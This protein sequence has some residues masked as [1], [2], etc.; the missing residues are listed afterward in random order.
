MKTSLNT[1]DGLKRSLTVEL[2]IDSFNEKKDKIITNLSKNAKIDGFRK[3]KIPVAILRQRFG[4]NASSDATNEM[5]SESLENA[6][7]DVDIM[8]A[9][10]PALTKVD[11]DDKKTFSYTIEFEVFPEINVAPLADLSIDQ[12]GSEVSDED[13]KRAL[14][15]LQDRATEYKDVKRKSKKGDRLIIDFEGMIDG[16][17]FE[18]GA[19]QGFEIILGRGTMIDGFEDGLIDVTAGSELEVNATFPKEYSVEELSSKAAVFKVK[20]SEVGSPKE[21][22]LDDSLA[23]HF[24]EKDF[25]TM[26][27]RLMTQM[28]TELEARLMQQNKDV[29]FSALLE[30]NEFDVPQGSVDAEATKL[31]SDMASRMEQQ[32]VPTKGNLPEGLF[33]EEASRRVKL[34]LLIN[35]IADDNEITADKELVNA[36]LQIMASTYGENAQQM[37]DWY[38]AD[39]QRISG[40]ES[41]V[42]E[43]MVATFITGQAKVNVTKKEFLEIMAPQQ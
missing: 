5:V 31:Q 36:K 27:N 34:G 41:I 39:P 9:A 43:E 3:G 10:Q 35:K 6:L 26:K 33:Q 19:A 4:A 20:V 1:L 15:E 2:P 17:A 13:E 42:Q 22:K 29:I 37:L 38:N 8:P 40:I 12:I 24:G 21:V 7:K 23:K 30:A 14:Q 11:L 18:G 28:K 25:D 32:G 16:E